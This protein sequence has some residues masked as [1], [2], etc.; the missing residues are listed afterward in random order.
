MKK[1]LLVLAVLGTFASAASAQSAITVYGIA[2]AGLVSERGGSAGSVSKLTSGIQSGSRLGFRG[3]EDLGGGLAAIFTLE[4]GLA[5]DTGGFNQG[6][7]A[8]G[9]QSFVGLSSGF[10]T[11]TLGRQYTPFYLVL[12]DVADPFGVGLAGASTNLIPST[13]TR[14]NN[15]IKYATPNFAGFNGEIAY[16]FGEV[17]GSTSA[18]RA[19]GASVGYSNGPLNVRLGY[20]NLRNTTDTASARNTLLAANYNF[21]V[22][23]AYLAYGD[24]KGPGS[25][26]YP[27]GATSTPYGVAAGPG[28]DDSRD[29]LVGVTVPFGQ[30]TLLASYIRKDDRSALNNDAHQWAIGYTYALSKRTNLY[31]SYARI[32]N[33]NTAAYTVGSAIEAGSGDKAFNIGVRHVF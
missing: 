28:S 6:G 12:N 13:G 5:I 9:R 21:N 29:L 19:A 10:G 2:D 15:T 24:N 16:G 27:I 3:R 11:V 30:S 33:D 25:S 8:F 1:S 22:A 14:M 31:T 26:P 17:A 18:G 32:K 23:K 20:H 4:T 7:L